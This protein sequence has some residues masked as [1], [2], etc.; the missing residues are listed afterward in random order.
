MK[1]KTRIH[2]FLAWRSETFG[3]IRDLWKG[4]LS[5]RRFWGKGGKKNRF[6]PSPVGRPDTQAIGKAKILKVRQGLVFATSVAIT[7]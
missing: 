5:I 7:P 4:S 3:E 2:V 6:S 1:Y